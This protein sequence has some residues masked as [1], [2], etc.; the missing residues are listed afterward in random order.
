MDAESE[1]ADVETEGFVLITH[2]QTD[3]CDAS[4]HWTS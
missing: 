2:V 4:T 3:H 1:L